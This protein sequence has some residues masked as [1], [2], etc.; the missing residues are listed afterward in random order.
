VRFLGYDGEQDAGRAIGATAALLPGME[1]C[2]I[3]P[4]SAGERS[5]RQAKLPP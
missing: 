5:L 2:H 4:K 1:G 3:E